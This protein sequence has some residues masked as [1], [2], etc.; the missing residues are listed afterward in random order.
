M[1]KFRRENVLCTANRH[2]PNS[3]YTDNILSYYTPVIQNMVNTCS[4]YGCTSNFN[5]KDK[6]NYIP[7]FIF[8][9]ESEKRVERLRKIT[10]KDLNVTNN[11]REAW[12][13]GFENTEREKEYVRMK[14]CPRRESFKMAVSVVK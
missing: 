3:E 6:I 10:I 11:S 8:P 4:V 12:K 5:K 13:D 7:I 9:K 2:I 14:E 1:V